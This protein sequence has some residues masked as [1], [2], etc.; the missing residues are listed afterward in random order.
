MLSGKT[1]VFLK[2]E[3][4]FAS[5]IFAAEKILR[6]EGVEG[7]C[8]RACESISQGYILKY[9]PGGAGPRVDGEA[10]GALVVPPT[11][12]VN[13]AVLCGLPGASEPTRPCRRHSAVPASSTPPCSRWA[14][15]RRRVPAAEGT[16]GVGSRVGRRRGRVRSLTSPQP[17]RSLPRTRR[18]RR[19]GPGWAAGR[20][21]RGARA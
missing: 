10:C 15:S 5:V 18:R 16:W 3:R 9:R 2:F 14:G 1:N 21:G 6:R 12:Q 11:S 17:S 19:G 20:R 13:Q 8:V 4:V 7:L